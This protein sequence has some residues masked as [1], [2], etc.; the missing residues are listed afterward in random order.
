LSLGIL[1]FCS[2][3]LNSVL[4]FKKDLLLR[5]NFIENVL[6]FNLDIHVDSLFLID[7][8][9]PDFNGELLVS[10]LFLIINGLDIAIRDTL[11]VV[12]HLGKDIN[13]LLDNFLILSDEG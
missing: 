3:L 7:V 5:I 9:F 10:N 8:S 11:E 12:D 6:D 2:K 13:F 1:K 4:S